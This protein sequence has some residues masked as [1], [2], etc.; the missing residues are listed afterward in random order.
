MSGWTQEGVGASVDGQKKG[1]ADAQVDGQTKG[2]TDAQVDGQ[3]K[4]YNYMFEEEGTEEQTGQSVERG[5]MD[6]QTT[7]T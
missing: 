6:R 4:G 7:L 5:N 1:Q 2:Q 3:K